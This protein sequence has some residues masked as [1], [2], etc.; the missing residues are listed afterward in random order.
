M[1]A[2]NNGFVHPAAMAQGDD[3]ASPIGGWRVIPVFSAS[4]ANLRRR[5]IECS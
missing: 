1:G 2:R 4:A 5:S 3:L